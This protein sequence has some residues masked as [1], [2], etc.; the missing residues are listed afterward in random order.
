MTNVALLRRSDI[1]PVGEAPS[2]IRE[3]AAATSGTDATQA[4]I[5][6]AFQ[7]IVTYIPTEIVALYTSI[8]TAL[9]PVDGSVKP[10]AE[11]PSWIAFWACLIMT[12]ASVW[13]LY[14]GKVRQA[15]KPLPLRVSQWPLWEMSAATIAFTAWAFSMPSSPFRSF[16]QFYSPGIAAIAIPFAATLLTLLANV[17]QGPIN[18]TPPPPPPPPS[19][20]LPPGSADA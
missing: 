2:T 8:A 9:T 6:G 7:V 3:R 4:G 15:S 5:G 14:A 12:P 13:L 19:Q 11:L 17:F 1:P 18:V 20:P 16:G 10:G